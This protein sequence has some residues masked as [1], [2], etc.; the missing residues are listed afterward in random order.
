MALFADLTEKDFAAIHTDSAVGIFTLRTGM[1][2]LVRTTVD[3]RR[4]IVRVLRAGDVAGLEALAT[5]RYD[6]E[7][8]ALTQVS[9]CRIPLDVIHSLSSSSQRMHLTLMHKW[10]Q[11]LKDADDWLADLNFGTAQQRVVSLI[12]KMRNPVDGQTCTLFARE[13]MGSMLGLELETVSRQISKLVRDGLISPMDKS[14]RTYTIL[15]QDALV[16]EIFG[17][18]G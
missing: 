1:L 13:D 10:Q 7:A 14:G 17:Q 15:R 9:V 3:G 18:K 12:L 4:R 11:A 6:C 16:D 8:V 5:A 2:K